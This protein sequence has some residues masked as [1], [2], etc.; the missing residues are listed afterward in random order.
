LLFG[1]V[2]FYVEIAK[3]G[4]PPFSTFFIGFSDKLIYKVVLLYLLTQLINPIGLIAFIIPGIIFILALFPAN[5]ILYE[6]SDVSII[7][8][9]K[10]C[11]RITKKAKLKLLMFYLS[12]IEWYILGMLTLGIL[13][14][15]VT[16]YISVTSYYL[17]KKLSGKEYVN[18]EISSQYMI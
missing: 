15:Y 9:I 18:S 13:F 5:Y 7:E 3:G 17:Y 11:F 2:A 16:P 14:I 6:N 1:A 10:E 4:K 8:I 12:F